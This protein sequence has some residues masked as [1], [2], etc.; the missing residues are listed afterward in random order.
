MLASYY[1]QENDTN[2]DSRM[3]HTKKTKILRTT[4]MYFLV[5]FSSLPSVLKLVVYFL[6]RQEAKNWL[7]RSAV[8]QYWPVIDRNRNL[9]RNRNTE[10]SVRF[11]TKISAETERCNYTETEM[12]T[13]TETESFR[14]LVLATIWGNFSKSFHSRRTGRWTPSAFSN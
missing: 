8:G 3:G 9:N 6:L 2:K 10:I 12:H 7:S 14:S 13:E 5:N 11:W 1:I 4:E